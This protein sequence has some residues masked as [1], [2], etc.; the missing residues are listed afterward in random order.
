MSCTSTLDC[1]KAKHFDLNFNGNVVSSHTFS[2]RIMKYRTRLHLLSLERCEADPFPL[3]SR[4]YQC[5]RLLER[6]GSGE[7][8]IST[9]IQ[10]GCEKE[11]VLGA[12]CW[13]VLRTPSNFLRCTTTPVQ[14]LEYSETRTMYYQNCARR[15]SNE[16]YDVED[17]NTV[18]NMILAC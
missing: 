15:R 6:W 4:L 18:Q 13:V 14:V 2:S 10:V 17:V 3:N 11:K 9:K 12:G 8:G 7:K 1:S 16:L 5:Q